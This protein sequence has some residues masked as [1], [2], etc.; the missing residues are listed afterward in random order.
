M[1]LKIVTV[2]APGVFKPLLRRVFGIDKPKK[3]RK[4]A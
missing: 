2:K 4:Q 1:Q 3:S